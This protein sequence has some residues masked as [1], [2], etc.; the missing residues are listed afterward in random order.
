MTSDFPT[1]RADSPT[2]STRTLPDDSQIDESASRRVRDKSLLLAT[3]TLA[4]LLAVLFGR[5]RPE[6]MGIAG[7]DAAGH[8][9]WLRSPLIDGDFNFANDY[10]GIME[11]HV[12]EMH[13]DT[14]SETGLNPNPFPIGV[15]VA[16]AP[17]ITLTHFALRFTPLGDRWPADGFSKPYELAALWSLWLWASVG[18]V[19]THAWLRRHWARREALLATVLTWWATGAAYYTFPILLNNHSLGL[20][21]M[22]LFLLLWERWEERPTARRALLAG[23]AC[24][25]LF[26]IRWQL[27]LWPAV[28]WVASL[29][30]SFRSREPSVHVRVRTLLLIPLPAFLL[31]LF[32]FA[33]WAIIYGQWLLVPQGEGYVHWTKPMVHL[34]LFSTNRGWI[35]WTPMVAVGLAGLW[36]SRHSKQKLVMRLAIGLALQLYIS[37]VPWD[38]HGAWGYCARRLT[39]ATPLIA[40]GVAAVLVRV[41][42]G[43]ARR[44]VWMSAALGLLV[45][46]NALFL[47]QVY[48]HLIPYHR[49]LTLHELVGDKFHLAASRERRHCVLEVMACV[50][51]MREAERTDDEATWGEETQL[52]AEWLIRARDADPNH[53]DIHLAAAIFA[54]ATDRS[55]LALSEYFACL[56][57]IGVDK[58]QIVTSIGVVYLYRH[59]PR[60]AVEFAQR[61]L[62]LRPDYGHAQRLLEDA[63]DGRRDDLHELFFF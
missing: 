1:P 51:R 54:L 6:A 8:Y 27:S 58:P 24:G 30:E 48:H 47:V 45:V 63:S 5:W 34:L 49:G 22:P 55:E 4:T 19:L 50:D 31:A 21:G 33:G 14:V 46:W 18:L 7:I 20:A 10:A 26:L 11:P 28:F 42:R 25:L 61:A 2:D 44:L 53:E 59:D 38:W 3:L 41:G 52:A 56:R 40:F 32:Q 15:G 17:G 43:E 39:H 36:L 9:A 60:G 13:D 29:V 35:T 37:S 16:L 23:V 62:A 57:S 12:W